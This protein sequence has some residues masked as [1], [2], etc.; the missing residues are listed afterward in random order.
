MTKLA[1]DALNLGATELLT[2]DQLKDL[3]GGAPIQ[4]PYAWIC[5]NSRGTYGT[6][7][8]QVADDWA[9]FWN[10]DGVPTTCQPVLYV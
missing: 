5:T 7:S 3:K 10:A 9:A 8:E 4:L 1:L 2:R 6:D